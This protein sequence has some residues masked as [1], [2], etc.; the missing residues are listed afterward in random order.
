MIATLGV[1]GYIATYD[2]FA[3]KDIDTHIKKIKNTYKTTAQLSAAIHEI[4]QWYDGCV[5]LYDFSQKNPACAELSSF[6]TIEKYIHDQDVSPELKSLFE[7]LASLKNSSA[8]SILTGSALLAHKL[9]MQTKDE[10]VPLLK[11]LGECDAILSIVKLYHEHNG[12]HAPFC[13]PEFTQDAPSLECIHFWHPGLTSKKTVTNSV[14]LGMGKPRNMIITG[15][16][17]GGKSTSMAAISWGI[18]LAQ[19]WGIA[20]AEKATMRVFTGLRTYLSPQADLE[21]G[22]STFM[23][24]KKRLDT[25]MN[26]IDNLKNSDAYFFIIDEPCRGTIERVAE[27]FVIQLCNKLAQNDKCISVLATHLE[28]PT[29]L[30]QEN[31]HYINYQMELQDAGQSFIRT[32]KLLPGAANW[33]FNDEPKRT[34]FLLEL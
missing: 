28:R 26:T 13:L 2:Y 16:N 23:A 18:I 12:T 5:Q 27:Q 15:P 22:M 19:G 17:G 1:I 14:H 34:R 7:L 8:T 3:A 6:K 25:I 33:W 31:A 21:H 9:L 32:F 29:F 24:E 30:A 4:A 11:A 20:P 10:L